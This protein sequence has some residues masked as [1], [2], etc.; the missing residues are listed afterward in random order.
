MRQ[1][2][3]PACC[4]GESASAYGS[5][6]R[7]SRSEATC[8]TCHDGKISSAGNVAGGSKDS[9]SL[10]SGHSLD[11]SSAAGGL[12]RACSSCHDPHG[13]A[14]TNPMIPAAEVNGVQVASTGTAWCLACHDD[15]SSWYPGPSTYPQLPFRCETLWAIPCRGHGWVPP[16][17]R[18]RQRTSADSRDDADSR[19]GT[20]CSPRCRGLPVLP[21]SPPWVQCVRRARGHLPAHALATLSGDWA[22]GDY[23]ELCFTCHGG[24]KPSGFAEKPTDIRSIVTSTAPNAGHRVVTAGGLLPVGS[25]LPCYEC[26]NPHGS[27][28]GND[29]MLSDAL[30]ASLSTTGSPAAT[31]EFCF[32]CHTTSLTAKGWDSALATYTAVAASDK[33]VGLARTGGAL[34]LPNINGHSQ[35]YSGSCYTCHGKNYSSGGNNVHNPGRGPPPAIARSP[36]TATVLV[37]TRCRPISPMSTPSSSVP[38][39]PSTRSTPRPATCVTATRTRTASTGRPR[40]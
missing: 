12:T 25:P 18:G 13:S 2:P 39:S 8:L 32:T 19:F 40:R 36:P 35:E 1:L 14:A 9:F 26:H 5:P 6:N 22:G 29:S 31:R 37:A 33:V 28:R 20:G 21:R 34:K 10:A 7:Y 30:G 15:R 11:T 17:T 27:T 3:H 16:P 38:Q 4:A 24:T 23:A